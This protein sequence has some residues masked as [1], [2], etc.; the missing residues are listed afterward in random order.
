MTFHFRLNYYRQI[1]VFATH[2]LK[3]RDDKEKHEEGMLS[4]TYWLLM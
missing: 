1:Y 4:T 2:L 3:I